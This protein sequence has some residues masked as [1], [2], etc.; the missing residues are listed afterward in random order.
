MAEGA[1][2]RAKS[3]AKVTVEMSLKVHG[4]S[5]TTT[6]DVKAGKHTRAG[7]TSQKLV[8][9]LFETILHERL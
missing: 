7:L 5:R 4:G 6:P 9:D 3:W 8:L 2:M 1:V